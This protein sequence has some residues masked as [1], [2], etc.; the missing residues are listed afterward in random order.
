MRVGTQPLW[1]PLG[2]DAEHARVV[3]LELAGAAPG[4]M[5]GDT[6]RWGSQVGVGGCGWVRGR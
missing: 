5:A 2:D 3:P 6:F 4:G 1:G